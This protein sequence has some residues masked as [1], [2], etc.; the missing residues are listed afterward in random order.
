MRLASFRGARICLMG[1][2][3]YAREYIRVYINKEAIRK[4]KVNEMK[5]ITDL[6]SERSVISF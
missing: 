6:M 1:D 2:T 3:L 5:E 4:C